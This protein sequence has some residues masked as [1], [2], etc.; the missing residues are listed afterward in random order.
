MAMNLSTLE[1]IV[2]TFNGDY[3]QT[4][5]FCEKLA[6]CTIEVPKK[7]HKTLLA[8]EMFDKGFDIDKVVDVTGISKCTAYNIKKRIETWKKK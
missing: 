4:F 2:D 8:F 6:G 5:E 3:L 7:A 1:L